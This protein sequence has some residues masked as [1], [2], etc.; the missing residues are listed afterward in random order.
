MKSSPALRNRAHLG[1]APGGP[2]T[3]PVRSAWPGT[4]ALTFCSPPQ[5]ADMLRKGTVRGPGAVSRCALRNRAHNRRLHRMLNPSLPVLLAVAGLAARAA[6]EPLGPSSRRTGLVIS[7]I[8]YHPLPRADGKNLE[9]IEIYNSEATPAD[10]SGFRLS[11]AVDFTFP[12]NTI[13]APLSFL[14]VAPVPADVQN[15]YNLT[16]VLG[17]FGNPTNGLPNDAGTIRLRNKAGAVL[18]EVTYSDQSPWP[19]AA[20]GAGHSLVLARP[21]LGEGDPRA[22]AS[23]ALIGGSPGTFEPANNDPLSAVVINEFLA[24]TDDPAVDYIELYNHSNQ[25]LD[26]SG[27][28][29]TDDPL[30]NKF[31]IPPKTFVA[32][33]GFLFYTQTN[34]NF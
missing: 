5:R 11:G 32:A 9:F 15:A 3:V 12:T 30:T 7:E 31:V 2:R 8:M 28:I 10:I 6:V 14:A 33:A 16:G 22:W 24:H 34:M 20:D 18:L 29:L 21:S 25:S 26:L 17:P 1:T 4:K 23:S 19:P 27:C 13:L